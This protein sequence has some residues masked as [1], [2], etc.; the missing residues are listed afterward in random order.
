MMVM[1]RKNS[2]GGE[3]EIEDDKVIIKRNMQKI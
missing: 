1:V 2:Q 3:R